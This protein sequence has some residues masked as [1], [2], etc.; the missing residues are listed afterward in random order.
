M[1]TFRTRRS[2]GS[3]PPSYRIMAFALSIL[4]V[5]CVHVAVGARA[6]LMLA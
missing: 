6:A 1:L 2:G 4:L 5:A 3:P